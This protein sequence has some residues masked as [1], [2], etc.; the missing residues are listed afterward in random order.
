MVLF[1][2]IGRRGRGRRRG[3]RFNAERNMNVRAIGYATCTS[4]GRCYGPVA[5]FP[6]TT[7]SSL[8]AVP[9]YNVLGSNNRFNGNVFDVTLKNI[10]IPDIYV[11]NSVLAY[12][13]AFFR[14]LNLSSDW[15]QYPSS[16]T[17]VARRRGLRFWRI[18]S[19]AYYARI[20]LLPGS[21]T[22]ESTYRLFVRDSNSA[23][24]NLAKTYSQLQVRDFRGSIGAGINS[25]FARD[26]RQPYSNIHGKI[27]YWGIWKNNGYL[28]ITLP[29]FDESVQSIFRVSW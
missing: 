9:V 26:P 20:C 18:V 21:T 27:G 5:D 19:T 4:F 22:A 23:Y 29:H 17:V 13:G 15:I 2:S 11:R 1:S 7:N 24:D 6:G 28:K 14:P 10:P 3:R 12:A 25:L 8:S 16:Y